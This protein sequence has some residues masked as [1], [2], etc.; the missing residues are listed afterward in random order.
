[1]YSDQ[2]IYATTEENIGF[3]CQ[4]IEEYNWVSY[5]ILYILGIGMAA[6]EITL[7]SEKFP[8][9]GF[10]IICQHRIV[11]SKKII[12]KFDNGSV[13]GSYLSPN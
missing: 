6:I 8:I 4:I 10:P 12:R 3:I 2:P 13:Q 5:N 9:D 11:W 1:M 7:R